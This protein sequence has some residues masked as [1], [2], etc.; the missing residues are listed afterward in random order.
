MTG[1]HIA[2]AAGDWNN[3]YIG[4]PNGV[5]VCRPYWDARMVELGLSLPKSLHAK[6][7]RM[8]PVLA[9]ALHDVLPE[10]IVTRSRKATFD[11]LVSGLARNQNSLEE[12]IRQAPIHEGI[13]NRSV[14]I[15]SL[16]KAGLGIYK[17]A[18]SVGRLRLA[19]S[20]LM[21]ASGREGWMKRPAPTLSSANPSGSV[22]QV[23]S[24]AS[25][26]GR[27]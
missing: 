7:G 18:I 23:F 10:K 24:I 16:E 27:T 6:P 12:M 19:L 14:L 17:D 21:W 22:G 2:L 3:W 4:L 1:E 26:S 5:V 9:A 25:Q 20:Y 15:D 8:K 11:I 13:M